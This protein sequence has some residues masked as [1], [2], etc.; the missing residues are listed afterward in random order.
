MKKYTV[1]EPILLSGEP[2]YVAFAPGDVVTFKGAPD[3]DGDVL[4]TREDGQHQFIDIASLEEISQKYRVTAP[5]TLDGEPAG[6]DLDNYLEFV[7]GTIVTL[8]EDGEEH[9]DGVVSA[10]DEE[11]SWQELDRSSLV[12]V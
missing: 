11:G 2:G 7:E 8:L 1:I 4:A 6:P 3:S 9:R 12:A 5:V 10:V